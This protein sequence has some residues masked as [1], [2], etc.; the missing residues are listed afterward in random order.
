MFGLKH[1]GPQY[2]GS[3]TTLS[4]VIQPA[5]PRVRML[6]TTTFFFLGAMWDKFYKWSKV[7]NYG[8]RYSF[9]KKAVYLDLFKGVRSRHLFK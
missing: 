6:V 7:Y 2:T 3:G 9:V 4:A 8:L 5:T 1:Y